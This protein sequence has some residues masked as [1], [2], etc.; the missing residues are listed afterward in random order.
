V[1]VLN[2][3]RLHTLTTKESYRKRAE[4][5]LSAF[6]GALARSP[7][8]LSELLLAVDFF[9]DVP[10]EIVI[11]TRDASRAESEPL[12]AA[13]REVFAPSRV[14]AVVGEGAEQAKLSSIVPFVEGKVARGGSP[15]AYVC[16][17]GACKLPTTDP[18][19]FAAQASA[20]RRATTAPSS[21]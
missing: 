1:H 4:R 14:L 21:R 9:H 19:T 13:F 18:A 15:T 8:S 6:G 12:L 20:S 2:L 3:L 5:A 10:K 7:T 16:E 11:V 17:R